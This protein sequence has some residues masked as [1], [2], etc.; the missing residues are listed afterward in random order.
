ML[1]N[2]RKR[3]LWR[4]RYDRAFKWRGTCEGTAASADVSVN[5]VRGAETTAGWSTSTG[6]VAV[7]ECRVFASCRSRWFWATCVLPA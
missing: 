3:R 6:F 4:G 2:F 1:R 5:L 7:L